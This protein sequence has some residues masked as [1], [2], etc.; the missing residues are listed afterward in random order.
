[1]QSFCNVEAVKSN[2]VKDLKVFDSQSSST[3]A[4]KRE[5][6]AFT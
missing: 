3:K 2:T 6:V 5:Q 4:K 1:M